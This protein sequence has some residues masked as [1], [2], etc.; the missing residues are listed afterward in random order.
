MPALTLI[1]RHWLAL[2]ALL[3]AVITALSLSPLEK[4]PE[5]PGSDKWHHFIAYAA[6]MFPAALRRPPH[7]W[8]VFLFYLG[9]SGGIELIQPY[10][11]R[12][13][14]WADLAA[15]AAGLG[16]GWIAARLVSGS[17]AESPKAEPR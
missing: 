7:L 15:N 12:Y 4:L 1:R 6:L 11:N 3:L 5:V 8:A 10:V 9:W 2:S 14:E 13:G 17:A 16:V